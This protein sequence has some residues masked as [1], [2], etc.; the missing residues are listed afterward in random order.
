MSSFSV[1][2]DS[3]VSR[4]DVLQRMVPVLVTSNQDF[5]ANGF[6]AGNSMYYICTSAVA[7]TF[8]VD[9]GRYK[10]KIVHV[11]GLGAAVTVPASGA[12]S[13]VV[14]SITGGAVNGGTLVASGAWATLVCDGSS[15]WLV[16]A[17]DS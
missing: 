16:M 4:S 13:G 11:S 8:P 12:S 5:N 6:G 3:S 15:G 9:Y 7:L 1:V 14:T 2:D 10:G 17:T